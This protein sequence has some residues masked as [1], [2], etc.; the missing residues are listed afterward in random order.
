MT[1]AGNNTVLKPLVDPF[2]LGAGRPVIFKFDGTTGEPIINNYG[3]N[4]YITDESLW[5]SIYNDRDF[6][7]DLLSGITGIVDKLKS[8]QVIDYEQDG[9]TLYTRTARAL[10]F[11]QKTLAP[12]MVE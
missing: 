8:D 11:H 7:A 2:G 10:L 9:N 3:V 12:L 1:W 6:E 4:N 5:G